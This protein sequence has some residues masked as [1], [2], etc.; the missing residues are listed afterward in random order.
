M[1]TNL[2][3]IDY[4]L[5]SHCEPLLVTGDEFYS[6]LVRVFYANVRFVKIGAKISFERQVKYI[7]FTLVEYVLNK[8]LGFANAIQ[9]LQSRLAAKGYCF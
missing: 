8:I 9:N 6:Q 2:E 3:F 4:L 5:R 1:A 7:K